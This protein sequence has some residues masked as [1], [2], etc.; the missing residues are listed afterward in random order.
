MELNIQAI[1]DS[2]IQ[3]MH[4]SG[5]IKKRIE[6]DVEKTVLS[7]I[8]SAINGY[9]IR[10]EIEKSVSKGVSSVLEDLDFT[11]YNGFIAEKVKQLTQGALRDDVAKKI[12][13]TFQDIF[14]VKRDKVKLSEILGAYRKWICEDTDEADKYS[15]ESF[16]VE[17][18][19]RQ[20][21][22]SWIDF[23]LSKEKQDRY[24]SYRDNDYFRFT[25]H[26]GYKEPKSIGSLGSV[27]FGNTNLDKA[28][29]INP[30]EFQSF[31]MNLV[32]NKTPVEIDI[33]DEDDIDNSFDVNI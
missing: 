19:D 15:L 6:D 26:R 9:E 22:Y 1:A 31:I 12:Q 23:T 4:E 14:I 28:L 2:K 13:D 30:N 29:T 10:R 16:F 33:E 8:G 32:Y 18:N 7:A 25:V 21:E 27:T 3:A 11:S 24:S 5:E 20:P 17:M